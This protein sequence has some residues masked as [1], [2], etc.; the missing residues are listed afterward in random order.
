MT[1]PTR[2]DRFLDALEALCLE[3]GATLEVD[4]CGYLSVETGSEARWLGTAF[5]SRCEPD[6]QVWSPPRDEED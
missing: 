4:R 5:P 2:M 3:H 1:D 6:R